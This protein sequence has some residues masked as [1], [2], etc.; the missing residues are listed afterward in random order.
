MLFLIV[1]TTV[2]M[3][4]A[5]VTLQNGHAVTVSFLLWQFKAPVALIILTATAARLVIGTDRV[6]A[7]PAPLEP[8]PTRAE[9]EVWG[10]RSCRS[11]AYGA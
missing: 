10:E 11:F 2:A 7:R 1:L 3:A 6:R 9:C 5:V 4:V 8:P